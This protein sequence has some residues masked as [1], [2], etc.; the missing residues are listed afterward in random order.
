MMAESEL[1]NARFMW[2]SVDARNAFGVATGSIHHGPITCKLADDILCENVSSRALNAPAQAK[3]G[4]S[5]L[6]SFAEDFTQTE[7][8]IKSYAA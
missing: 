4:H 2:P 3:N 7:S 5:S 1:K 8:S 6:S